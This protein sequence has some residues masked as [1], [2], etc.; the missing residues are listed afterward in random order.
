MS[1]KFKIEYF[2]DMSSGPRYVVDAEAGDIRK[3]DSF[4]SG[5]AAISDDVN[6]PGTPE[7]LNDIEIAEEAYREILGSGLEPGEFYKEDLNTDERG[8]RVQVYDG[9]SD[10]L[11]RVEEV[12]REFIDRAVEG[13]EEAF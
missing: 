6:Y 9:E 4:I 1:E 10:E 13:L 5:D 3:D 11:E 2:T 7:T 12:E 8:V